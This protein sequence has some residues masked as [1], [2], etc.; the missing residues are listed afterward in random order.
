MMYRSNI[1][2]K[3][4]LIN[5]LHFT[6]LHGLQC[7]TGNGLHSALVTHLQTNEGFEKIRDVI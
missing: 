2:Q 3:L 6:L 4:I 1:V 7:V 5:T